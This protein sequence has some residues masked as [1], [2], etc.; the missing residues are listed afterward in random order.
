MKMILGLHGRLL[1][2]VITFDCGGVWTSPEILL[3]V[4]FKVLPRTVPALATAVAELPFSK[5]AS[6]AA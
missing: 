1:V 6:A 4:L 2:W 3:F 5:M